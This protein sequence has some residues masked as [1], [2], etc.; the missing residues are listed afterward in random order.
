MM[1]YAL[2]QLVDV[3]DLTLC[4]PGDRPG[5]ITLNLGKHHTLGV[6]SLL[7]NYRIAIRMGYHCTVPLAT[8]CNVPAVCWAS[9]VMYSI[10]EEVDHLVMG[11]KHIHHLP[12]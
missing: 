1:C 7:D 12:G 9:I 2:E 3:P 11:L 5:V 8:Y 4:G 6:G 10:H